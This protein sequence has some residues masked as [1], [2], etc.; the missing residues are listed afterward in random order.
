MDLLQEF[1]RIVG[2]KSRWPPYLHMVKTLEKIYYFRTVLPMTLKCIGEEL[3]E[4]MLSVLSFPYSRFMYVFTMLYTKHFLIK[5]VKP[6]LVNSIKC[7]RTSLLGWPLTLLRK[8]QFA[9]LG[10]YISN[11]ELTHRRL[12]K[13]II[14]ETF[15]IHFL[16]Y[17]L[18]WLAFYCHYLKD[19]YE[20]Y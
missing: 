19:E 9:L 12:V 10:I 8:S 7:S 5:Y 3:Y 11:I 6:Y 13:W 1:V 15:K 17:L 4:R 18:K 16:L 14:N 20:Q 2:T